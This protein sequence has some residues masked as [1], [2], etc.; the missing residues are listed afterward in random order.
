[1]MTRLII[2]RMLAIIP[3]LFAVALGSFLLTR[4]IPGDFLSELNSNLQL[5]DEA[6][7]RLRLEYGLDRPWYSQFFIW[8]TNA[9][10]GDLG[11][12]FACAC[13]VSGL[14][15]ESV[16]NTVTLAFSGLAI[17]LMVALPLGVAASGLRSSLLDRTL[18]VFTSFL[19]S[20]PSFLLALLAIV[21]AAKTGWFPIG[22]VRSLEYDEFSA[23]RKLADFMHHLMLPATVLALRQ[24]PAYLRQMRAGMDE[25]LAQDFIVT[26]RAKGLSPSRVL[27]K[28]ALKNAVNP[29][30]T[31]LGAS[32]GS[33]LS[34]AFIVE[35]IM[36]WPGLG[37]LAVDSLLGRD[38]NVLLACLILAALLLA[39]GNLLA[40]I[41]LAA[42]DPRIRRSNAT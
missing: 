14:I 40:D 8:L 32:L 29:I 36:S 34:G 21:M 23:A 6:L 10:R 13:P 16:M 11:L 31:M 20:L 7:A 18:S 19:L 2:R 37:R 22:G 33:L 1:M 3:L 35:A 42:A 25:S 9:L 15:A 5:S 4:T 30:I 12:S 27:L 39:L 26:A 38:L 17:A 24:M 41:L 28:H